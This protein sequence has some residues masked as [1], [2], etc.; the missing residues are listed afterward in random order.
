MKRR[1]WLVPIVV[2]ALA[3]AGSCG[4]SSPSPSSPSAAIPGD[5]NANPDGSNLKATAPTPLSPLNGV[6]LDTPGVALT[7]GNASLKFATGLPL[8][9]RFEV[10]NAAGTRVYQSP[11]VAAGAT[12]TTHEVEGALDGDQTYSWQCR[13]E[14]LGAVGP[15]SARTS[16]TFIAPNNVGYIRGSELYDPLINGTT[17]GKVVG[18]VTWIPGVGLKLNGHESYVWYQLPETLTEGEFSVIT[19]NVIFNTEGNKT[20]IMAMGEGFGDIVTNDRR[21]TVEKRG[22]PPGVVAWRF[23]TH[24]DQVDTEGPERQEVFFDPSRTYVWETSWRSNFFNV[25]ILEGLNGEDIYEKGKH[26]QGRSYDP[27]PHVVYVGAPVG[28]SGPDSASVPDVIYRQVWV[29]SRPR[30]AFANK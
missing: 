16:A 6:R 1:F 5:A 11:S 13:V 26:F 27:D 25:R 7:V 14:Y 22:D 15:W 20:K 3:V 17:V 23:I 19:T 12:S 9:Y 21:M 24:G 4:K 8:T 18:S 28:R 30:P 2:Y 10:F 29:S